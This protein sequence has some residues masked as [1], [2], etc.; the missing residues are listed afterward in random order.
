MF[1]LSGACVCSVGCIV[2]LTPRALVHIIQ[3]LQFFEKVDTRFSRCGKPL[4]PRRVGARPSSGVLAG[5][6]LIPFRRPQ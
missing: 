2:N 6:R 3:R 5:E 4:P 1:T